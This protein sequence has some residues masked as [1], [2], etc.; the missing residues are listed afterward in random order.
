M[1][2]QI[3]S[4]NSDAGIYQLYVQRR[5]RI[6]LELS[7]GSLRDAFMG[8]Y[9][10]KLREQLSQRAL[11]LYTTPQVDTYRP[12]TS[13]E[14]RLTRRDNEMSRRLRA[15]SQKQHKPTRWMEIERPTNSSETHFKLNFLLDYSTQEALHAGV[16]DDVDQTLFGRRAVVAALVVPDGGIVE[17]KEQRRS[18]A[19]DIHAAIWADDELGAPGNPLAVASGQRNYVTN[20]RWTSQVRGK[21]NI[22]I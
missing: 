16:Y 21:K 5:S 11:F 3:H 17:S 6:S 18:A 15:V 1:A 7:M 13:E 20:I 4:E 9:N 8:M 14:M 10:E 22:D 19:H 12:G 2:E